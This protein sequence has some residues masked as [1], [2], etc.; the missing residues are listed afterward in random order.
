METYSQNAESIT[1]TVRN[2][3]K[4]FGKKEAPSSQ[5]VDQFVKRFRETRSL[6]A[7]TTLSRYRPVHSVEKIAKSKL[8]L[9][10]L[11]SKKW[12]MY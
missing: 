11:K 8:P 9:M 5:F 4:K 7:K 3:R 2:L 10:G 6:L 12:K 1:Q